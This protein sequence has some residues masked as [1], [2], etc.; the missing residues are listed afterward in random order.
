MVGLRATFAETCVL[1]YQIIDHPTFPLPRNM[2]GFNSNCTALLFTAV[3]KA[4]LHEW[5]GFFDSAGVMEDTS[6]K[7]PNSLSLTFRTLYTIYQF[8]RLLCSFIL[9]LPPLLSACYGDLLAYAESRV[10][11]RKSECLQSLNKRLCKTPEHLF[12]YY[13]DVIFGTLFIE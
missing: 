3:S 13:R 10:S 6:P 12:P 7:P 4:P 2:N 9:S 11:S 8:L 1:V 5:H